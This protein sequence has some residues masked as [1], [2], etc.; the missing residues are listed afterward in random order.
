MTLSPAPAHP[1]RRAGLRLSS[2]KIGNSSIDAWT[3]DFRHANWF[4]GFST[5]AGKQ[6]LQPRAHEHGIDGEVE[7]SGARARKS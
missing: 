7:Q 3:R 2:P 1:V 5:G 4:V 6:R